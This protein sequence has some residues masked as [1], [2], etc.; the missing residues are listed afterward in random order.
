METGRQLICA[1]PD[2]EDKELVAKE[3]K[4]AHQPAAGELKQ[5]IES[6]AY[7]RS[8][9]HQPYPGSELDDWLAAENEICARY[10]IKL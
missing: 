2:G 9:N 1:S 10:G 8:Q 3:E 7:Y 5:M 4:C 6:A